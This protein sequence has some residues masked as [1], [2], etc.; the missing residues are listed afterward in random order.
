MRTFVLV[1]LLTLIPSAFAAS[2][3][4]R[5]L[6]WAEAQRDAALGSVMVAR[7]RVE[8]AE[9]DLSVSRAVERDVGKDAAALSIAREAV[10]VS[11]QGVDE[12][13][14][15]LRRATAFLSRQENTITEVKKFIREHNS[16]KALVI[17]VDGTFRITPPSGSHF[18][19][20]ESIG[21][22]RKGDRIEVGPGSNARVFVSGGAAEIAL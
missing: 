19:S 21:S 13:R 14:T 3:G 12:A 2:A 6:A 18:D 20:K 17:P 10:A 4:E 9:G 11:E 5:A 15:L 1:L 16:N 8:T 7:R 22:L